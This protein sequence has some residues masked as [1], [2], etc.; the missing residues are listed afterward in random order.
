VGFVGAPPLLR[1]VITGPV[2]VALNRPVRVGVIGVNPYP[3]K[4][5]LDQ[6]QIGEPGTPQPF[7]NINHLRIG[8]SWTSLFRLALVVEELRVERPVIHLVR[9]AEQRFNVSD[10]LDRPV[11]A[12]RS[13]T[14]FRFAVSKLQL[15]DGT[16]HL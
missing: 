13:H 7:I 8:V 14:P 3:L 6:L 16:V 2:A 1:H 5:D 15:N 4:M 9:T 10:L 11:R 12:D